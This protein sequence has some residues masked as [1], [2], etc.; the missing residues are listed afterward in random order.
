M[1]ELH[2]AVQPSWP[3]QRG[4]RKEE[5]AI[6]QTFSQPT[7]TFPT[8][9]CSH[10]H[11][12]GWPDLTLQSPNTTLPSFFAPSF[13]DHQPTR[14]TSAFARLHW[15]EP[16][17]PDRNDLPPPTWPTSADPPTAP[18]STVQIGIPPTRTPPA[19]PQRRNGRPDP[20]GSRGGRR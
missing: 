6:F 4:S 11:T 13:S 14:A 3:F 15:T 12:T 5:A 1:I 20:L 18:R 9:P 17:H 16:K 7:C 2:A 8:S 10:S 19:R